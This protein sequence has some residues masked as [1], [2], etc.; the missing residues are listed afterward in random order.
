M[1][2]P[3]ELK[4]QEE[5]AARR[6]KELIF[7]ELKKLFES[8]KEKCQIT[9]SGGRI[10][11]TLYSQKSWPTDEPLI[12]EFFRKFGWECSHVIEED[13]WWSMTACSYAPCTRHLLVLSPI[14]ETAK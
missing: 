11:Y 5:K 3:E 13:S 4:T 2:T 6:H 7:E 12:K 1:I 8:A 9:S 10:V 14:N